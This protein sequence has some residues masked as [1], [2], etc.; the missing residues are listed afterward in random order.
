[1][2]QNLANALDD[3]LRERGP[4]KTICPSEI[5]RRIDPSNWKSQMAAV[6]DIVTERALT[7]DI[8]VLQKGEVVDPKKRRGVYRIQR[9]V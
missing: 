4:G 7:G 8:S 6:H 5:A 1:M 2:D 3:L 9:K